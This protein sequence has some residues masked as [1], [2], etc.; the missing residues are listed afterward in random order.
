MEEE[1]FSVV[2]AD[3]ARWRDVDTVLGHRGDSAQ[4]WC[5]WFKLASSEYRE[6]SAA[7]RKALL[8]E[9]VVRTPSPGVLAYLGDEPVG[10]CAV[11][12]R[13]HYPVLAR[14]RIARAAGDQD[15][16]QRWVVTCFVVRI[17]FRGR[18]VARALLRGAVEHA[19]ENG[20]LVLDAYPVDPA[21]RPSL[22]SAE[23]YHGTVTLFESAGFAVI[24]RPSPTRAAMRLE[25]GG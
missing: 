20:A 12:P 21:A 7:E 5:Q 18:G 11:E 23:K 10:W 1:T 14:S 8:R 9:Q 15:G 16:P 6:T 24:A 19:R 3:E 4:C 22:S 17:G 13:D 25:F 2:P